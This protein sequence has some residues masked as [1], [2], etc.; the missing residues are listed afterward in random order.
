MKAFVLVILV[1]ALAAPAAH[2]DGLPVL[3]VDVGSEGV[4]VPGSDSRFVALAAPPGTVVARIALRGGRVL[5]FRYLARRY[6]VPAVAYDGSVGGLSADGHTL[7]LLEPRMRFPRARTRLRVLDAKTLRTRDTIDL[8]GDFSFDAISPDG[9][10]LYLVH[11]LSADDP[12]YYEVRAYDVRQGRLLPEPI[13]DPSETGEQMRGTPITR[14]TSPDGRWAYT[15]YDGNGEP[16]VH[17]LDTVG[18][19]AR[20]IDLHGL[21]GRDLTGARLVLERGSLSI[22]LR[23]RTLAAAPREAKQAGFPWVSVGVGLLVAVGGAGIAV[24][25]RTIS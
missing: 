7:V 22:R 3:G 24:H 14:T 16:F 2:A 17:A 13:V 25:R 11:Y 18:R 19:T 8:Q 21:A 23:G 6:T 15:L 20:C 4:S 1:A 9:A 10:L 5:N 12:T